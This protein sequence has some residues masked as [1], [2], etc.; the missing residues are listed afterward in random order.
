MEVNI[1]YPPSYSASSAYELLTKH[2]KTNG[3]G[4]A[5]W[6]QGVVITCNDVQATITAKGPSFD[7]QVVCASSEIQLKLNV[8]FLLKPFS[9]SIIEAVEKKLRSLL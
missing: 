1:P 9:R 2:L 4:T 8:G 6:A 3:L 5:S 7:V